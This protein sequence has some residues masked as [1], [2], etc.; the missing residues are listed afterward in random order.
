V[1]FKW[2]LW[3]KH[4]FFDRDASDGGIYR[5]I[6]HGFGLHRRTVFDDNYLGRLTTTMLAG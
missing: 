3:L 5:R 2:D 1:W 4:G 6:D